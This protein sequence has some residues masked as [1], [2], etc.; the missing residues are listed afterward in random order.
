[1]NSGFPTQGSKSSDK[2]AKSARSSSTT[3]AEGSL[4][5]EIRLAERAAVTI[6]VSSCSSGCSSASASLARALH[7]CVAHGFDAKDRD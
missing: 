1:M 7:D 6:S 5:D 3:I 2:I 4:R